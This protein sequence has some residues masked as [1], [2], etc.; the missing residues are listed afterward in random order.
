MIMIAVA[1]LM[2]GAVGVGSAAAQSLG[3]KAGDLGKEFVD[4]IKSKTPVVI[5][6]I[7]AKGKRVGQ[8]VG[9][10][11]KVNAN[12]DS[13]QAKTR[14]VGDKATVLADSVLTKSQRLLRKGSNKNADKAEKKED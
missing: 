11:V 13:L 5:D 7:G 3:Q 4:T 9:D 1:S 6:S 2:M 14:R 10:Y 8:K 12:K